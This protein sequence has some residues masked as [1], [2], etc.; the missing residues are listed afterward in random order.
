[1]TRH[2][3]A[4]AWLVVPGFL[5][6]T[7]L[8]GTSLP[9]SLALAPLMT[10]LMASA[11]VMVCLALAWPVLPVFAVLVGAAVTAA[12]RSLRAQQRL[13][14]LGTA[15]PLPEF[16][17]LGVL[18]LPL[19]ALR[20]PAVDWDTRSIW[21]FHAR[22]VSAGGE[23]FRDALTN[24]VF[25]F[26]HPDYPPIG[27]ATVGTL[28]DM[29]GRI[30]SDQGK[31]VVGFLTFA[32]VA[33]VALSLAR[34]L[35]LPSQWMPALGAGFGLAMFGIGGIY[36]T[37]GHVDLLW[38]AAIAGAALHLLVVPPDRQAVVIGAVCLATAGLAKNEG[39][40]AA[41]FVC[42]L[43]VLRQW[44]HRSGVR[45]L[46]GAGLLVVTW[47]LLVRALGSGSDFDEGRILG[48]V[49]WES[50]I[51]ARIWPTV[52][53]TWEQVH[54]EAI[55]WLLCSIVSGLALSGERRR[56]RIGSAVWTGA[57]AAGVALSLVLA[58]VIS[59]YGLDFHL[60]TS[61]DRTMIAVRVLL[62]L[63]I[64][65]WTAIALGTATAAVRTVADARRPGPEAGEPVTVPP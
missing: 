50:A 5:P 47:P 14:A 2:L 62:L 25:T 38:G 45:P 9:L 57:A 3:A 12:L 64:A 20:R 55:L 27:P 32:A 29:Q 31:V 52:S 1:V 59:P 39:M 6:A 56:Q 37:N 16:A 60:S 36:G 63:D 65:C 11:A 22:W 18:L 10:G 51:A 17:V 13:P 61:V 41:L 24:P 34:I 40:L 23:F 26:S 19:A 44:H 35:A 58:Y 43:A 53:A 21:L 49:R 33:V 46:A 28:W 4:I 8:A 48:L 30:D 15:L 7:A 42:G 54:R